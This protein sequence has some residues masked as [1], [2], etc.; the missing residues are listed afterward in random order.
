MDVRISD[1]YGKRRD[2]MKQQNEPAVSPVVGV[3]LMLVVVIIIAAV[4]SGF[5]GSL[6]GGNNQKVPKLTMDAEIVNTGFWSSSYFK[7]QV[8]GVDNPIKTRDLKIITSWSKSLPNGTTINGGATMVPGQLNYQVDHRVGGLTL[9]DTWTYVCPQGYGPGVGNGTELTYYI[10]PFEWTGTQPSSVTMADVW[11]GRK[12]T[13]FSWFG[14]YNLQAGTTMFARP[15][16]GKNQGGSTGASGLTVGYGMAADTAAGNTGGGRYQ[17]SYGDDSTGPATF[18]PYPES[19]DQMQ[20]VLG[21][22]WNLLMGGDIVTMKVIHTP[23][24]KVIW[25]KEISVEG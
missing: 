13:N 18:N 24:G 9:R 11:A 10:A 19:V 14:N 22:N 25:Q 6:V 15:F 8:T 7:A 16:G 4:V 17:Y 21:N 5:A 1:E 20:A 2:F 23:S 3:M 12:V